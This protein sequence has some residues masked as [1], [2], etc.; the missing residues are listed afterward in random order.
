MNLESLSDRV[1]RLFSTVREQILRAGGR[2][3]RLRPFS[4]AFLRLHQVS[5]SAKMERMMPKTE[6]QVY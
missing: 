6:Y 3:R 2:Q 1:Y 5:S 4:E